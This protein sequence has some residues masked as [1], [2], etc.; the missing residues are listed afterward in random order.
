MSWHDKVGVDD[1]NIGR[2]VP[3]GVEVVQQVELDWWMMGKWF[4]LVILTSHCKYQTLVFSRNVKVL[5]Y[6]IRVES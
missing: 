4:I 5:Y 2:N 3:E 1:Y 6:N